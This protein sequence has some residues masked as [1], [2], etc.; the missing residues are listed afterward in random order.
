MNIVDR[1]AAQKV[2]QDCVHLARMEGLEGHARAAECRLL[3]SEDAN[4]GD[5]SSAK[6]AK[7]A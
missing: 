6:K 2:V 5:A 1:S 3:S 4:D 7:L